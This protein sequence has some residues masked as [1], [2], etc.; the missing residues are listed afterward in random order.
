MGIYCRWNSRSNNSRI[1][2][3]RTKMSKKI[4]PMTIERFED[5]VNL[6]M[7]KMRTYPYPFIM[8]HKKFVKKFSK[9]LIKEMQDNYSYKS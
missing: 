3:I 7:K 5:F 2:R 8:E 9:T 1:S 6:T 4:M